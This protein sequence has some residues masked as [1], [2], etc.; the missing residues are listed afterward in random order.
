MKIGIAQT[1]PMKGDVAKN[2]DKHQ[3]L[4]EKGLAEGMDMIVFPELSL[5]GY[6]P[7]LAEE[8]ALLPGDPRLDLFQETSDRHRIRIGVGAPIRSGSGICISMVIFQPDWP[9]QLYSKKY[10][11][12]D[13]E[14]FFV[15]G[16]AVPAW[17]DPD[18]GVALAICYELSVP[19]H[20][21]DASRSGAAF[22]VASVAKSA[23]GVEKASPTLA[24]I[25]RRYGM[26][27]LMAN[28]VGPCD[29]FVAAGRSSVWNRKGVLLDQL[30]GSREGIL[31][32]DT[33]TESMVSVT[34]D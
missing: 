6:E 17:C 1:R 31:V 10:L 32:F 4:I 7:V 22:Y 2:V 30:D 11:H 18:P 25:A 28:S 14:P 29:D 15:P 19:G 33:T 20:P 23:E 12:P 3:K 27:V 5:T 34:A 8:L 9:R 26:T 13:E 24:A 16:D 21:A